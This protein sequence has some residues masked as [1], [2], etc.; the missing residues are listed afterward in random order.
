VFEVS[1]NGAIRTCEIADV[2]ERFLR[3]IDFRL[4]VNAVQF[5]WFCGVLEQ[6]R[7][8]AEARVAIRGPRRRRRLKEKIS[9]AASVLA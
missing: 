9:T 8:R 5:D 3:S 1:S 6:D 7:R 2:E 4:F